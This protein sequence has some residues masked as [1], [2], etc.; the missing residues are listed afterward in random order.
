METIAQVATRRSPRDTI[1]FTDP[2]G[3]PIQGGW[4]Y[5]RETACIIDRA[6]PMLKRGKP[7]RLVKIEKAFVEKRIYQELIIGRKPGRQFS[8]IKWKL[9]N[10]QLMLSGDKS[11]D[12]LRFDVTAFRDK[13]WAELKEEYTGANGSGTPGFDEAAHQGKRDAL[14]VRLTREFWFDVTAAL[15][16]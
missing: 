2:P 10:Q 1:A 5:D 6:D 11:F 12:L 15:D 14:L 3:L 8:D 4:G 7:F 13:D 9:L 16:E